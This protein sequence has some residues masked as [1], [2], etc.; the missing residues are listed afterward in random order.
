MNDRGQS[1]NLS[2]SLLW[3]EREAGSF[4]GTENNLLIYYFMWGM[5]IRV[6]LLTVHNSHFNKENLL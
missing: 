3:P 2:G 1:N 6:V 4:N 5:V